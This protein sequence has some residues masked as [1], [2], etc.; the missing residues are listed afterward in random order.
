ML[1]AAC[2][3]LALQTVGG[4]RAGESFTTRA[5]SAGEFSSPAASG[6]LLHAYSGTPITGACIE[7]W[8]E[9]GSFALGPRASGTS[10]SDG[11]FRIAHPG[12]QRVDKL[13][14]RAKGFRSTTVGSADAQ[15][16]LL[17]PEASHLA[18]RV[19]DLEGNPIAKALAQTRQTCAHAPPAYL[20]ESDADG[21]FD[22]AEFPPLE[23]EP[24][25]VVSAPGFG[26]M[27]LQLPEQMLAPGGLEVRLPRRRGIAFSVVDHGGAPLVDRRVSLGVEPHWLAGTTDQRGRVEFGSVF[28]RR[29]LLVG[30]EMDAGGTW[31]AG[32]GLA[33][34]D[35]ELR[36]VLPKEW[37][38]AHIPT[39][40]LPVGQR[41]RVKLA[42]ADSNRLDA[43]LRALHA[44]GTELS[45]AL[46]AGLERGPATLIAGGA[47]S[48][49]NEMLRV[50]DKPLDTTLQ[51]VRE[52]LLTI[53]L[54]EGHWTVHVQCGDD[55]VTLEGPDLPLKQP[56]P[57]G[58]PLIVCAV[59]ETQ[60]RLVHLPRIAADASVDLRAKECV[61]AERV[62]GDAFSHITLHVPQ[63]K[64]TGHVR[65][66]SGWLDPS[67]LPDAFT[68]KIHSGASFEGV[69]GAPG[70]LARGLGPTL[71]IQ[72]QNCAERPD[73]MRLCSLRVSGEVR[74]LRAGG[75]ECE[76]VAGGEFLIEELAPGPLLAQVE[77]VDGRVIDLSLSLD[78]GE[79]RELQV[80]G[81]R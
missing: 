51:L 26:A 56:V 37:P 9:E 62:A 32:S 73:L 71:E 25:I 47:F 18:L 33:P 29:E 13:L 67:G 61:V 5:A 8:M 3:A 45:G 74:T 78:E 11:S 49:W 72:V 41:L 36:F 22:L 57:A 81:V 54:P 66:S 35:R 19:V 75:A 64:L 34:S 6:R 63:A 23:D 79:R 52:P 42:D 28:F 2:W 50:L 69:I 40:S 60:T 59:N 4:M 12:I 43:P 53:E 44:D 17:W 55:S 21:R 76:A 48:G 46:E 30:V 65:T 80:M 77:L 27:L 10:L 39:P 68:F 24:E 70:R 15:D 1:L 38:P 58:G 31:P 14:I 20:G 16:L 7:A